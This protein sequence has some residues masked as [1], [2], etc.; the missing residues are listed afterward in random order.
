MHLPVIASTY[1][2][3][4][5]CARSSSS[6]S[7]LLIEDDLG[8]PFA[9]AQVQEEHRT[10]ITIAVDPAHQRDG[11]SYVFPAECAAMMRPFCCSQMIEHG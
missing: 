4:T 11:L 5:A 6:A 2:L 3:R 7:I 10:V 9:I 8:D 1:S